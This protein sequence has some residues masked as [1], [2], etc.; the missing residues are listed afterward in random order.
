MPAQ[1]KTKTS[2]K[3]PTARPGSAKKSTQPARAMPKFTKSPP[4]MVALF[5]RVTAGL[6]MI[7]TRKM[8]GYPAA[9][10][11]GQMFASLFGDAFILRLPDDRREAFIQAHGA[12]LFEPMPG[13]PMREYVEVPPAL[14][15][16]AKEL[17]D[18]LAQGLA[19]AQ[20]LPPKS[21][22]AKRLKK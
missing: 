1:K 11:N 4:E 13:R 18:W 3:Q 10:V 8:F 12:H 5:E 16:R 20:S 2:V 17:D 22:K 21:A 6:P 9:F 15:K 19:Y 14:L 7:E